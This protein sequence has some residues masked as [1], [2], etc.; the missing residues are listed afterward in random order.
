M[1]VRILVGLGLLLLGCGGSDAGT[2]RTGEQVCGEICGWPDECYVQLG[3][4][5]QDPAQCVQ[6][7]EAQIDLVGVECLVAISNTV[8]CLGT[9]DVESLTDEELLACQDEAL[10]ISSACE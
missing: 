5:A 10:A 9:C 6:S 3:V 4:P 2:A 8:E 1:T 7:C